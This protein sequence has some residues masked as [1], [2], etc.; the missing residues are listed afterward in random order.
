MHM[1]PLQLVC[2]LNL[3][4]L[5][6]AAPYR[7]QAKI[8]GHFSLHAGPSVSSHFPPGVIDGTEL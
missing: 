6:N 1:W 4:L 5:G 7:P 3:H 8:A 2:L